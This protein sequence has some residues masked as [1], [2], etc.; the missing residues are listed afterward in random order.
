MRIAYIENQSQRRSITCHMASHCS[1][2]SHLR[3]VNVPHR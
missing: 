3:Q 1:V 2:A